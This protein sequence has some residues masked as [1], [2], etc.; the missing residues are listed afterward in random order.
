VLN[1]NM[2]PL[3]G[4]PVSFTLPGSGPG[5]EF[6]T[7][8]KTLA[9]MS[10]EQGEVTLKAIRANRTAGRFEIR[11]TASRDNETATTN[12]TQFNMAVPGEHAGN[13]K[14]IALIAGL[15]AAGAGG[16]L[17]VTRSS[18]NK[19]TAAPPSPISIT[20]GSGGFGPPK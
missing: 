11:V 9:L 20:P 2:H 4:I 16:A 8:G 14:W 12:I 17:A 18:Q 1:G 13:G 5:G 7:G 10:N 15:V 6:A 3:S 19:T